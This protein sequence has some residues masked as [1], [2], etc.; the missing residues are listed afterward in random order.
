MNEELSR[1]VGFKPYQEFT[2]EQKKAI[3]DY[4]ETWYK[5]SSPI[6][7]DASLFWWKG[8]SK[9]WICTELLP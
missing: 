6:T 2:A 8:S 3:D 7:F 4:V 1:R 9:E 5:K